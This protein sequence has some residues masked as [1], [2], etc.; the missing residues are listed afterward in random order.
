LEE[1]RRRILYSVAAIGLGLGVGLYYAGPAYELLARPMIDA[2]RA[3]GLGDKLIFTH[4]LGAFRVYLSLGLYL[5]IVIAL[6]LVLYQVW[7]FVAPGLYRHER[8]AALSFLVS[9]LLLFAGGT[10][11]GYYV[12]LPMMLRFLISFQGPFTPVIS[13]NEYLDLVVVILLLLGLIFQL[14]ILIF[15]LSLFGIVT[16]QFLWR[17]FRYAVLLIAIVAAFITP[18][19]DVLTMVVFMA[20]MVLLYLVGIGVSFLVARKK[21]E[22]S[23][24][25]EAAGVVTA[26]VAVVAVGVGVA[27][28]LW[29]THH[30]GWWGVSP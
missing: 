10:A 30:L 21:R 29:A 13:I 7:L 11:F 23:E 17:N 26:V 3:A 8:R 24:A 28:L 19:T 20:P 22:R 18:T 12:A 6:P 4:P 1:L 25:K 16:P 15:F 5:G 14:P 9:S 27:A 2:L